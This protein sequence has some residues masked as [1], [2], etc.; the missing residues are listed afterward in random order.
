MK[1]Q[2]RGWR[3]LGK[4]WENGIREGE[5]KA[6]PSDKFLPSPTLPGCLPW[7]PT[8]WPSFRLPFSPQ[9]GPGA[10]PGPGLRACGELKKQTSER[11]SVN[12]VSCLPC[13]ASRCW[14]SSVESSWHGVW[15]KD[16]WVHMPVSWWK[17][18]QDQAAASPEGGLGRHRPAG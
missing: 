17:K 2:S 16:V 6:T 13:S 7:T 4:E 11:E 10:R 1:G 15:I 12:K 9:P 14:E 8:A 18:D 5:R 3:T